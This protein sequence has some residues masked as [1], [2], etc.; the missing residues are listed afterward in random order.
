MDNQLLVIGY[1]LL[2][3]RKLLSVCGP[4]TNNQQPLTG[5]NGTIGS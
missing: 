2:V 1:W 4:I 5:N 3:D